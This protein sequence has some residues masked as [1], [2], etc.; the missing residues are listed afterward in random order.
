MEG[1]LKILTPNDILSIIPQ[2][3]YKS[4]EY[5]SAP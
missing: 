1:P 2:H 3:S 5:W 4:S